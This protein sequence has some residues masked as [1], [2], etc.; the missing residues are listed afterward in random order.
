MLVTRPA[1]AIKAS[2]VTLLQSEI[3]QIAW[4]GSTITNKPAWLP[5]EELC[6]PWDEVLAYRQAN[7]MGSISGNFIQH[8]FGCL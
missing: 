8:N 7:P 3:Q 4:G 2:F 1:P 6:V 5:G